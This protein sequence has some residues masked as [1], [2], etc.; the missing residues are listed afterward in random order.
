MPSTKQ[1]PSPLRGTA[2]ASHP[3]LLP[4]LHPLLLLL[5]VVV[6][7]LV[8]W[9]LRAKGARVVAAN[10]CGARLLCLRQLRASTLRTIIPLMGWRGLCCCLPTA[11]LT[12]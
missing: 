6:V 10:A 2:T 12:A 11:A 7:V 5:L 1:W 4:L 3:L 8:L 9:V